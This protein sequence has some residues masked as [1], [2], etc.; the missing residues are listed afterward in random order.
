MSAQTPTK[1]T[2]HAA[3]KL[4][5]AD[6]TVAKLKAALEQAERERGE[7]YD[8]YRDLVPLSDDPDERANGV[9]SAT[10]GGFSIRVTPVEGTDRFSL[11]AYL[12]AGHKITAEM[13][14]AMK[15]SKDFHRWTIRDVRGPRR[16]DAV[17]P[18]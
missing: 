11:T 10:I 18:S 7:L 16:A 1:L 13:Q 12:K 14:T 15:R 2:P 6:V 4:H 17:E 5:L 8:R 3:K 9:R